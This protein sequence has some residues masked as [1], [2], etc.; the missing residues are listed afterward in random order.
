M[1]ARRGTG[2]KFAAR[3]GDIG[4]RKLDGADR[5]GRVIS[6]TMGSGDFEGVGDILSE[7]LGEDVCIKASENRR[8]VETSLEWD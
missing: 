3:P 5:E 7:R 2:L 4:P 6:V 8:S 1:G